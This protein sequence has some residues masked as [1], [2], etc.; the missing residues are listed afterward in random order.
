MKIAGTG[1][2]G[3][4]DEFPRWINDNPKLPWST[5]FIERYKDKI[6]WELISQGG[7][8][9]FGMTFFIRQTSYSRLTKSSFFYPSDRMEQSDGASK[10]IPRHPTKAG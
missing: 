6:Q 8:L 5:E 4:K 9:I 1:G 7:K 2:G 3:D 10:E